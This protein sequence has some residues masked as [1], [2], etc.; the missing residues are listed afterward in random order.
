MLHALLAFDFGLSMLRMEYFAL[1]TGVDFREGT[2][3]PFKGVAKG[4]QAAFAITY[5]LVPILFEVGLEL[6]F[7]TNLDTE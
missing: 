6:V 3:L 7:S 2:L 5:A 1:L 4:L